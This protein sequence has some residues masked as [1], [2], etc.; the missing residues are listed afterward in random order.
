MVYL[1]LLIPVLFF[2]FLISMSFLHVLASGQGREPMEAVVASGD[3]L[4]SLAKTYSPAGVDLRAYVD[5]VITVN[6]LSGAVIYPGQVL[7][8]PQ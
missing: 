4:W 2:I 7:L 6:S 5:K 1:K 8:M 3:T